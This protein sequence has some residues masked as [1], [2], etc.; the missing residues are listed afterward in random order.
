M[1]EFGGDNEDLAREKL[2]LK[3]RNR[4]PTYENNKRKNIEIILIFFLRWHE[5]CSFEIFES[6]TAE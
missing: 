1:A 5:G 4:A 3:G 6:M 2:L